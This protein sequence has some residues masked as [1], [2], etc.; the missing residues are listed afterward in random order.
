MQSE[1]MEDE[2]HL[3]SIPAGQSAQQRTPSPSRCVD[4]N[5]FSSSIKSD[6]FLNSTS[7]K[8][9]LPHIS[10]GTFNMSTSSPVSSPPQVRQASSVASSN[11]NGLTGLPKVGRHRPVVRSQSSRIS[12]L[13]QPPPS[14]SSLTSGNEEEH[15]SIPERYVEFRGRSCNRCWWWIPLTVI[16]SI[17]VTAAIIWLFQPYGLF[18]YPEYPNATS[19]EEQEQGEVCTTPAC[20]KAAARL[21]ARLDPSIDPCTDFYRFSCGRFLDTYSVPDDSNQLSTLQEMQDEMLLST[22]KVLEQPHDGDANVNG[23][24]RKIKD[25]YASCMSPHLDDADF[26]NVSELPLF[27]F[28]QPGELGAWPLLM[29]E[30]GDRP[31]DHASLEHLIGTLAALQV[32]SFVDIYVTQDERNSSQYILQFFKGE[33]LMEKDWYDVSRNETAARHLRCLR[34]YRNLM[35]ETILLLSGGRRE[36]LDELDDMLAF[37][38]RFA[39][40]SS[41]FCADGDLILDPTNDSNRTTSNNEDLENAAFHHDTIVEHRLNLSDMETQFPAINWTAAVE[42]LLRATGLSDKDRAALLLSDM[43]VSLQCRDFLPELGN[44]LTTTPSRTVTNYLIWRFVYKSMPLITTRFLKMWTN[45][46]Q[47]VPNLGEERI[48]LTRWKQCVALVNE[49]FG[50]VAAHLYVTK[51]ASNWTNTWILRLIDELK[52]AFGASITRQ[53]WIEE[54]MTL[55]LLEKLEAMGSKI[56]YPNKILNLTQ[57]DLDYQELHIDNGHIL[58]NVMRIRRHEVWREIQK[59]FQPPPKEKEWLVQPLVVNAF[60]NPSTNEIIFPLGILREPFFNL[61]LPRYMT[62]GNLGVVIGHEIVHGFDV[63]GRRYDRHGNMTQWWSESLMRDFSQRADC[64]IQQYAAFTIDHIDKP[65][66]GNRTLGENVCDS[67]GLA[68]AWTAYKS[69]SRAIGEERHRPELRLPGVNYTDDQLFFITYGQIWCEVL[70]ADGYEKYTKEAHSPG[71]YRANGVLQN[72]PTFSE[73]FHCP[74]DSPMNPVNK[75][76]LWS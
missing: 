35:E 70:N 51:M 33:P 4:L 18:G 37:E 29:L 7:A 17:I 9:S 69:N 49:G 38:A 74:A 48:Y 54:E 34:S 65:V 40:I 5:V 15:F 14:A 13:R 47:S 30:P 56:G 36:P 50:L 12:L 8:H 31:H 43:P 63:N 23:S 6:S 28:L 25:F 64:F 42:T 62:Y 10:L 76:Q 20:V 53:E 26:G 21:L 39:K 59:V 32:H 55:R 41:T 73:V 61:D 66:D 24:I 11:R 75:C 71:K 67:G 72:S 60:H 27:A 19:P 3:N 2:S 1:L 68:H 46:K 45:F 52:E 58:F 44:L 16:T 57:L 22:R